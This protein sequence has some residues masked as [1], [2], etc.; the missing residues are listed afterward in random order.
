MLDSSPR[1]VLVT[2]VKEIPDA[3]YAKYMSSFDITKRLTNLLLRRAIKNAGYQLIHY[4][5]IDELIKNLGLHKSDLV[6]PYYFGVRSRIRQSYIQTICEIQNIKFIGAD[7]YTQTIG[8]DK[9]LSKEICRY[10][11]IES[12]AY[13]V[14][15]ETYFPDIKALRLPL[16]VKPQ[17]EGDS[18]GIS[19]K[20]VFF[21]YDDVLHFAKQLFNDLK[22]SV[23][24]E[25]Y[26]EGR[27]ISVC[28]VGYKRQIKIF[29]A[30]E[31]INKKHLVSS[32][33]DK[34][35]R[36]NFQ[37]Y[38]SVNELIS[39]DDRKRIIDL[40]CYLDKIEYMR[41]DFIFA[42]GCLY[43]IEITADP[44]LSPF[45]CMY[46]SVKEQMAYSEFIKLLI[47]NAIDRYNILQRTNQ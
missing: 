22:Q 30:V 21:S 18:I 17:F 41:L 44:D 28:V 19:D 29:E 15:D 31:N 37:K 47:T 3:G 2:N 40:F 35:F 26:I 23:L 42:N 24:I 39:L 45:S 36:L 12:P 4:H 33:N 34:K 13:K 46:I 38:K 20:N 11:G 27:E 32:Y 43:N 16:I 1:I 8:N 7:A 5:S 6:F 14:F 25:E 10:S 9:A